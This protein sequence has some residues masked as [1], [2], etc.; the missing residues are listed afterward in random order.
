MEIGG[1]RGHTNGVIPSL[2]LSGSAELEIG[3][4]EPRILAL[5][6]CIF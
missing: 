1:E 3:K 5:F 6:L 2:L 4:E